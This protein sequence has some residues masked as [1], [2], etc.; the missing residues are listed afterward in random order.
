[1]AAKSAD[2]LFAVPVAAL[3]AQP[4]KCRNLSGSGSVGQ[5][6]TSIAT[7]E[8]GNCQVELTLEALTSGE[9]AVWGIVK[10][11]W[12]GECRRCL[13]TV[14]GQLEVKV[15]EFFTR[16]PREGETYLLAKDR[17]HLG[18]MLREALLLNMP[19]SPLCSADC[20][21]PDP[22]FFGGPPADNSKDPRWAALDELGFD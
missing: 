5:L 14:T 21:G 4:G 10:A 2:D 11:N 13:Q 20:T 16:H 15:K 6:E 1:M 18:D 8:D 12:Q 19:L 3:L 22:Q 17:I 9:I 7:V